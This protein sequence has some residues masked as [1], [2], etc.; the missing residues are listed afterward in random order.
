MH[1][2][3]LVLRLPVC[4]PW[5]FGEAFISSLLEPTLALILEKYLSLES[6]VYPLLYLALPFISS[7]S[8]GRW[9]GFLGDSFLICKMGPII[10][11]PQPL[12]FWLGPAL[13]PSITASSLLSGTGLREQPEVQRGEVHY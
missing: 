7:V 10:S 9:L 1:R 4:I 5:N 8:V 11:I 12:R 3:Q 6:S 2:P 13:P